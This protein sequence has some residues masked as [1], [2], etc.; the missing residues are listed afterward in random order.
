MHNAERAPTRAFFNEHLAPLRTE[1]PRGYERMSC[2]CIPRSGRTTQREKNNRNIGQV[3]S[4]LA[5]SLTTNISAN[6]GAQLRDGLGVPTLAYATNRRSIGASRA[7]HGCVFE[8]C[9]EQMIGC[10]RSMTTRPGEQLISHMSMC[11]YGDKSARRSC[12]MRAAD[13]CAGSTETPPG[14]GDSTHESG[15]WGIRN[16]AI[17]HITDRPRADH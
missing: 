12:F 11:S 9:K 14:D 17:R 3:R 6:V 13:T 7:C 4:N 8:L 1:R 2:P 5:K 15:S 10:Y 16:Y